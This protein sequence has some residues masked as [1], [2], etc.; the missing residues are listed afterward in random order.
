MSNYSIWLLTHKHEYFNDIQKRI[1]PEKLNLFDG[2]NS[3]SFSKLINDCISQSNTEI[4][5][6]MSYKAQPTFE[7]IQKTL[8]LLDKGY[9]FVAL[10]RFGFFSFKKQLF[11]EIGPMDERYPW[12]FEDN[13]FYIRLKEADLAAYITTEIPFLNL[14]SSRSNYD[15]GFEHFKKK[16]GINHDK[17]GEVT[18][19]LQEE[20]YNYDFGSSIP[21][22]WLSSNFN[23]IQGY[24]PNKYTLKRV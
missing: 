8:N 12:G 17:A 20:L 24:N 9:A 5:I 19:Q 10:Y 23:N 1:E 22:K 13:D 15:S 21:C 11:R 16:W 14:P 7:H 4:N 6:C 2:S 3:I 18:R